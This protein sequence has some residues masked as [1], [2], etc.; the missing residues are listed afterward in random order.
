MGKD[1]AFLFYSSDFL[2]QTI[3]M[4]DA[5]IGKYIKIICVLH[6]RSQLTE[7]ELEKITNGIPSP[8]I[9]EK[10]DYDDERGYYSTWLDDI[11]EKR[12]KHS[13]KQRENVMRRWQKQEEENTKDI[14]EKYQSDTKEVPKEENGMS[15]VD[16]KGI[17]L[18]NEIE[19]ENIIVIKDKII[20]KLLDN[21]ITENNYSSKLKDAMYEWVKYKEQKKNSYKELGFKKLLTQIKNN[22]KEYGEDAIC[23]LIDECMSSN[24]QGLIFD[25]L[26]KQKNVVKK[27]SDVN[28]A[29]G[30]LFD[31][32]VTIS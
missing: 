21:F 13:E 32:T 1:P 11:V 19:N 10:L 20:K 9:L 14:P 30:E 17:P 2:S 12:R 8:A 31:G 15:L 4:E 28:D 25:K 18:E 16:T 7:P 23:K 22:I 27:K 5:D 29:L 24:Y 6:Q 26:E 3:L